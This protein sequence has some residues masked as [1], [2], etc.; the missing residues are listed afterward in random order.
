MMYNTPM[1]LKVFQTR[2]YAQAFTLAAL[3]GAAAI[4]ISEDENPK[5]KVSC[6]CLWSVS[7]LTDLGHQG[8]CQNRCHV[9]TCLQTVLDA[10]WSLVAVRCGCICRTQ[11]TFSRDD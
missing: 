10:S 7:V 9:G 2:I 11:M 8:R 6:T 5:E 3:C 1:T 4:S